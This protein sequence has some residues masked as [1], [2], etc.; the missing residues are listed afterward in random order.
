VKILSLGWGVQSFTLAAMVAL[1][2]LEPIDYAIHADTTHES[3]LTYEFADRWRGWLKERGVEVITVKPETKV[4]NVVITVGNGGVAIPAYT[5]GDGK[6]G[7]L[8]RQCTGEWKIK[9]MRRHIQSIRS[10]DKI[11]QWIGISLDEY[12]RMKM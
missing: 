2:E 1:G 7:Q 8:H 9:P 5:I 4:T 12:Q 11:E 3:Q 10:G 6:D